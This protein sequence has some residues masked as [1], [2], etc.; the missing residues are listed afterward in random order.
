MAKEWR[1]CVPS[2]MPINRTV[3][4]LSPPVPNIVEVVVS[5]FLLFLLKCLE[6]IDDIEFMVIH[7]GDA[8]GFN[9][10][11]YYACTIFHAVQGM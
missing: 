2:Y 8:H 11:I 6:N 9:E 7:V 10:L 3:F 4:R 1:A 5:F